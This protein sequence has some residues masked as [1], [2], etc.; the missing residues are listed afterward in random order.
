MEEVDALNVELLFEGVPTPEGP[1]ELVF[2]ETDTPVI[3]PVT[4]SARLLLVA[5]PWMHGAVLYDNRVTRYREVRVPDGFQVGDRAAGGGSAGWDRGQKTHPAIAT[6]WSRAARA[7]RDQGAGFAPGTPQ[8]QR[9]AQ[10]WQL[11]TGDRSVQGQSSFQVGTSHRPHR[12]GSWQ[13]ASAE[14]AQY[15]FSFQRGTNL[16]QQRGGG[17]QLA[18][19]VGRAWL[20]GFRPS[21][22][23]IGRQWHAVPWGLGRYAPST[24]RVVPP[25]DPGDPV[26]HEA[27]LVFACPPM[28]APY[29][30]VFG[31]DCLGPDP[32]GQL[33]IL[34]ARFYMSSHEITAWRLPDMAP[35]TL[36]DVTMSADRGSFAWS[37]QATGPD[38]LFSL[39]APS[40]GLPTSILLDL[41]G[42]EWVF[43]I[44]GLRRDVSFA[45]R[46]VSITG[47]SNTALLGAPWT[48]AG[49]W[50]N[51]E[52]R[53]AQ[54][55]AEAALASTGVGLDWDIDD[56]LV[57][58]G[59]WSFAGTPLAAVQAVAEAAGGHV[60]SHRSAATLLVRHPYSV[61]P[62]LW[63]AETPAVV[64]SEDALI[65]LG[66]ERTDGPDINAVHVSGVNQ[67]ILA[68]VRRAGTAADKQASMVTDALNTH[69][70]AAR[71]R[72]LSVLGAAGAKHTVR[73]QAPVLT[74]PGQ[75]GVLDVDQ[76]VEIN[77]PSPW[78]GVVRSV[79]VSY[80]APKA[81][82]N[83][84][85]ERHL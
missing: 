59:A 1:A 6:P 48:R 72:G 5:A 4:V 23:R 75:P 25:I 15:D 2:G 85:L 58:A 42:M 66:I 34:P 44:E 80:Q 63:G 81:R 27:H 45:R 41:D 61:A 14:R 54:Q 83:F 33:V 68:R 24:Q 17:W 37:L 60:L 31:D 69:V 53:T 18:G 62:W 51:A 32:G 39:L 22:V 43:A 26:Y 46:R 30:L 36:L 11:G 77:A 79:S 49:N 55:L 29:V 40:S 71:Q 13:L 47:R 16:R 82:Q 78:R 67:G 28:V 64:I 9:T 7:G 56:W 20:G 70:V 73:L 12:G 19:R 10:R 52:A 21:F 74:G 3:D 65:T 35:I 84:T 38:E 8:M 50:N 76:L 57:P